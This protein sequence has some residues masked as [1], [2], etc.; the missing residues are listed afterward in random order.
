MGDRI[1]SGIIEVMV[2]VVTIAIIAVLVSQQA[3]TSNVITSASK[4][5]G[6]IITAAVAPVTGGS[7]LNLSGISGGIPNMG[8]VFS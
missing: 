4:G 7:G 8:S 5:F 1:I 3:Q 2:L 6:S